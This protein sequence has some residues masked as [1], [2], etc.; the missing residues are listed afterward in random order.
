MKG[1]F[2]YCRTKEAI[3]R[4]ADGDIIQNC[5]TELYYKKLNKQTYVST[6]S[7]SWEPSEDSIEFFP[8]YEEW[9]SLSNLHYYTDLETVTSIDEIRYL[10]PSG[11]ILKPDDNRADK[12]KKRWFINYLLS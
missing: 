3:K 7:F 6:D 10:S 8:C 12:S 1:T 2:A 11:K 4:M 5:N 9:R